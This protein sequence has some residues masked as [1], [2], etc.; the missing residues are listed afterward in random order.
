MRVWQA[1]EI[2]RKGSIV[3]P[4]SNGRAAVEW[5][6]SPGS[7][8]RLVPFEAT[9]HNRTVKVRAWDVRIGCAFGLARRY[10]AEGC[11]ERRS[12]D[13]GEEKEGGDE[14]YG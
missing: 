11:G 13:G 7:D 2:S 9:V 10:R 14:H 4:V 1:F 6:H 3:D 12:R 5:I 8:E